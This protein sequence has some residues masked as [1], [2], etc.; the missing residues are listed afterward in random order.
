MSKSNEN[1]SSLQKTGDIQRSQGSGKVTMNELRELRNLQEEIDL[2]MQGPVMY[3]ENILIRNRQKVGPS[4][5]VRN[6]E[7]I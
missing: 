3:L 6:Q 7:C 4:N 2:Q 5:M 1:I